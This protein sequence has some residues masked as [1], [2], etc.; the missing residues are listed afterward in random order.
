MVPHN[1]MDAWALSLLLTPSSR[2]VPAG[3]AVRGPHTPS[4]APGVDLSFEAGLS[5]L[6]A[7]FSW[8]P[9]VPLDDLKPYL[10]LG[11]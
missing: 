2:A 9:N 8:C 10:T 7:P 1:P 6:S 4:R 5:K 11:C 3:R